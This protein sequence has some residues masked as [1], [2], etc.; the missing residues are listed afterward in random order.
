MV[1]VP[2]ALVGE[3]SKRVAQLGEA[4]RCIHRDFTTASSPSGFLRFTR[5]LSAHS[6]REV[7][8]HAP[9]DERGDDHRDQRAERRQRHVLVRI[10]DVALRAEIGRAEIA[11]EALPPRAHS[12]S[13]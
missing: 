4:V 6:L 5:M 9:V 12:M 8:L 2:V 7:A 10:P 13:S 1:L 11:A 3:L